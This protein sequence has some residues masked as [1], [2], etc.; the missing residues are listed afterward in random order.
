MNGYAA[1]LGKDQYRHRFG[2]TE[3]SIHTPA[4]AFPPPIT[5]LTLDMSDPRVCAG[6]DFRDLPLC[7]RIDGASIERQSY[8]FEPGGRVIAFE[9][10]RWHVPIDVADI[11]P[12]P[13]VQRELKLRLLRAEE[14]PEQASKYDAQ[15]TFLGGD[16]F[17][18]IRGTPIWLTDTEEVHCV[19]GREAEFI[20]AIGYENYDR[21]SGIVLPN[22]ALFIGELAL[23]F[24]ACLSCLRVVV[25]SQ[26]S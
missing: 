3:W 20:A 6:S 21:P 17:L 12:S 22:R 10:S 9:G 14:E 26:P 16:A 11:L 23:Y 8:T 4:G 7:S 5:L 19:C 18:R 13:L 15:D 24:F 25:V 1:E 2:G